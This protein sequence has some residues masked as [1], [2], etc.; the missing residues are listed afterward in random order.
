MID[1][2]FW[3]T[4]NGYKT[5][6][7]LEE[8]D[9]N[10]K[11]KHGNTLSDEQLETHFLK[12]VPNKQTPAIIDNGADIT[13]LESGAI[14]LYLAEKTDQFIPK[15][16]AKYD[17]IQWLMWQVGDLGPMMGQ[18]GHFIKYAYQYI[19]YA[20]RRYFKK[21]KRLLKTLEE[22]LSDRDFITGEYNIA[23][24]ACYPW[25][26]TAESLGINKDKYPNI[27]AWVERIGN[28]D[29]VKRA[30]EIGA[31]APQNIEMVDQDRALLFGVG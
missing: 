12:T 3:P 31:S 9:L 5:L 10:Y 25:V 27:N 6:I 23:D 1:L 19:P 16:T 24:M 21:T 2:Y 20:K 30:Y 17:A 18:A 7:M 22:Q 13:L 15:G 11:I 4:T 28:R 26:L 29:A 8:L 14:L